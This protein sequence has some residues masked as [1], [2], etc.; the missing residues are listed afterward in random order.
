M[1][2]GY[3]S[4]DT[5]LYCYPFSEVI[6]KYDIGNGMKLKYARVGYDNEGRLTML[7]KNPIP[8]KAQRI[9]QNNLANINRFI[10]KHS[11]LN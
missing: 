3:V 11:D 4:L 8:K 1:G 2:E 6:V 10:T 5:K 9:I 7:T